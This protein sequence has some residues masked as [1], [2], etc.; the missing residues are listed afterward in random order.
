MRRCAGWSV[1]RSDERNSGGARRYS[2]H[3]GARVVLRRGSMK[4][5]SSFLSTALLGAFFATVLL[6]S[7]AAADE[8]CS[9]IRAEVS[10]VVVEA[11]PAVSC[12]LVDVV[13]RDGGIESCGYAAAVA[14]TNGCDFA[15]SLDAATCNR[16]TSRSEHQ[17]I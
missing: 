15:I 1:Q 14:I 11:A 17:W 4:L 10:N 7:P 2:H 13:V 9:G 12:V 8:G 6:T 3:G 16:G 5:R